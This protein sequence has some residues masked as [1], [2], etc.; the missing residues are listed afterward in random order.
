MGQEN[1]LVKHRSSPLSD[2]NMASFDV[3]TTNHHHQQLPRASFQV[4]AGNR[5]QPSHSGP[6]LHGRQ[7]SP[8]EAQC[9]AL[10]WVSLSKESRGHSVL[11]CLKPTGNRQVLLDQKMFSEASKET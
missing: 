2:F 8:P 1:V 10:M 9:T 3:L 4:P 11:N 6:S 7:Q 5:Q